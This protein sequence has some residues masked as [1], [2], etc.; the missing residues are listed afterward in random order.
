MFRY[1]MVI[2]SIIFSM[3]SLSVG[4]LAQELPPQTLDI[5]EAVI[6]TSVENLHAQGVSESFPRDVGKLYAFTRV[7]GAEGEAMIKHRW[8][9]GDQLMTEVRLRVQSANWRTY[10]SKVILPEWT[11]PWKVEVTDAEGAV[12]DTL[13]FTIQ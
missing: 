1:K 13:E 7:V 6:A 12:I 2:S 10:S 8:F 5:Q 11:G 9:R 3:V 4:G